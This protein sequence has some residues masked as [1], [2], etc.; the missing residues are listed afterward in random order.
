MNENLLPFDIGPLNPSGYQILVGLLSFAIVYVLLARWVLPR[1]ADIISRREQATHGVAAVAERVRAEA[2]EVRA[3]R[4]AILA[5]AR[6][7]AARTRQKAHE[8]GLALIDA[9]RAEGQRERARI[10]AEGAV[11][12]EAARAVAEAELRAD[13]DLWGLAMAER[14]VGEALVTGPTDGDARPPQH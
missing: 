3:E 6:H 13:V 7:E 2:E 8:D 10:L 14:V 5:E 11:E 4:D 12:I 9:A 1:A